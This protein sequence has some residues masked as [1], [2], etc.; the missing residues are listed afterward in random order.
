MISK[1]RIENVLNKGKTILEEHP[2]LRGIDI[3]DV[4]DKLN[5]GTKEM[6]SNRWGVA[7]W[8]VIES[9]ENLKKSSS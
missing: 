6:I 8:L 2:E 5:D 3:C 1:E 7:A 9:I 4:I